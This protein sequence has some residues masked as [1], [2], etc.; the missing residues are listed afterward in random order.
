MSAR[1]LVCFAHP[2]PRHSRVHVSLAEAAR[3]VAGVTVHD[4][5]DA[6][7]ELDIDIE[8][9]QR[10]LLAHEVLVIQCPMYW[11]SV[12]PLVK[13]WFDLVLEHGW[14]YGRQGTALAGKRAALAISAG[15][16]QQAYG[17][18]GNNRYTFEEFLRPVEATM[19]LCRMTWCAPFIVAGTHAMTAGDIAEAAGRYAAWL[20]DLA[21]AGGA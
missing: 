5:Y 7:P 11:Y 18:E 12:P 16:R 19:R 4:L 8:A 20:A 13:Q 2:A 15:G 21:Q 14:A 6:Y 3:G 9:E 17:P 10:R 1:V